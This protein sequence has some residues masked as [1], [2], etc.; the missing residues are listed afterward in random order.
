[1]TM[2]VLSLVCV[3]MCV[4]LRVSVWGGGHGHVCSLCKCTVGGCVAGNNT[5]A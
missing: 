1:M 3:C 4:C 5:S 2:Q